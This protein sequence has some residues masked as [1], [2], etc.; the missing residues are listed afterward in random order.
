MIILSYFTIITFNTYS[1]H[2]SSQRYSSDD[3]YKPRP[4][5]SSSSRRSRRSNQVQFLMK[6]NS[7]AVDIL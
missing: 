2:R 7:E 4:L 1:R 3:L 5:F 6:T